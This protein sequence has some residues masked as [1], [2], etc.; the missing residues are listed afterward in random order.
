MLKKS[1]TYGPLRNFFF[2]FLN[3]LK[4]RTAASSTS[5]P[6]RGCPGSPSAERTSRTLRLS[7]PERPVL[8][9]PLGATARARSSPAPPLPKPAGERRRCRVLR[10]GSAATPHAT[11][12]TRPFSAAPRARPGTGQRPPAPRLPAGA[13][14]WYCAWRNW[15]SSLMR[16][17]DSGMVNLKGWPAAWCGVWRSGG[18]HGRERHVQ[19]HR[20]RPAA[21]RGGRRCP[22]R[23]GR[24]DGGKQR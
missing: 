24:R 23:P 22:S 20:G 5:P 21:R 8:R 9:P 16:S 3:A 2:F 10:R 17:S 12:W 19:T 7:P 14:L 4:R 15:N 1:S 6:F 11:A 13:H 18:R